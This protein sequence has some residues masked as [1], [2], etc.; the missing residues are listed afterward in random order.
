MRFAHIIAGA[1]R[2]ELA[3]QLRR[4]ALWIGFL[5]RGALL[6]AAFDSILR[7]PNPPSSL[8]A[9]SVVSWAVTCNFLLTLGAGLLL[10]DRYRRDRETRVF[11][12]LRTAPAPDWA[13]L[14]GKYVGAVSATLL[15]ILIIYLAGVARLVLLWQDATLLPLAASAFVALIVPPVFF[16]GSFSLACT[17]VLWQPLFM[18]LFVGYWL[19]TSLNPTGLAIPTLTSTLLAP[20]EQLVVTGYFGLA[21]PYS[22]DVGFYPQ[23]SATLATLNILV[24]LAC[25]ACAL[26]SGLLIHR[27]LAERE[28]AT[29]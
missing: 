17:I 28:G 14:C 24:L 12:L 5:L 11:E 4:R 22:Q 15:P 19:W 3:M 8:R 7:S 23:S 25:P 29:R 21:A 20:G 1:V 10:V 27:L 16:V 26:L 9:T 18:F 13:R 2:Y 6:T